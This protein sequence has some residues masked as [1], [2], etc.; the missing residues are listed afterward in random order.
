M[1]IEGAEPNEP[2]DIYFYIHDRLGSVR[3]VVDALGDV[4]N[5]YTYDPTGLAFPEETYEAVYNPFLFT[6]QWFDPEIQQYYLRARMY[7]P[8]LGVFTSRDPV[9]GKFQEPLTL[10]TYLYCI[11]NPINMID[12]TGGWAVYFTGTFMASF[13]P[14]V[15]GQFGTVWDDN[16]NVEDIFIGGLGGGSPSVQFGITVGWS[17]LADT[18]YDLEGAGSSIGGSAKGIG[19]DTFVGDKFGMGIELTISTALLMDYIPAEIHGHATYTTIG[20]I[21]KGISKYILEE[22]IYNA[23]TW[24]E[25]TSLLSL[26]AILGE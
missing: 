21:S 19:I 15:V 26:G 7:D 20:I 11:N 14:S 10:H 6:G 4:L 16:G 22:A 5:R 9:M 18:V 2:N 1:H 8:R 23:K 25:A 13:G 17:P 24:G 12:I 3:L